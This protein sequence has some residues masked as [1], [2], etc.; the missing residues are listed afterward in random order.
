MGLEA[1]SHHLPVFRKAGFLAFRRE[2]G[3]SKQP[4]D[5]A[6]TA[7]KSQT[8]GRF[9]FALVDEFPGSVKDAVCP[10]TRKLRQNPNI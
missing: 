3:D 9:P 1:T 10:R 7:P 8:P 2:A 5:A 6:E 4:C